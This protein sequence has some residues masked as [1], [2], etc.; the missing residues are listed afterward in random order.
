M[1]PPINTSFVAQALTTLSADPQNNTLGQHL[2]QQWDAARAAGQSHGVWRPE[3][4]RF[5]TMK[6]LEKQL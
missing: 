1:K 3:L 4:G 6:E 2:R 5:I